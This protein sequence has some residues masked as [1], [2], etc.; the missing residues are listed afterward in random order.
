MR[1]RMVVFLVVCGVSL[2]SPASAQS[3]VN[4][5]TVTFTASV[6]HADISSYAIGYFAAG[7]TAPVQEVDLGKP[8]PG[9]GGVISVGIVVKP[10]GWVT[11]YTVRV[12]AVAGSGI[13]SEWS[14]DSNPFSRQPGKPGGP[15]VK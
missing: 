14:S 9:T 4:P 1:R 12:K 2:A 3:V 11:G 8:T 7:A 5:T 13:V 6:D 10:L 15:V